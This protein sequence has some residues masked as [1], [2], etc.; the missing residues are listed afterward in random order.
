MLR[1]SLRLTNLQNYHL[2]NEFLQVEAIHIPVRIK[3]LEQP[4]MWLLEKALD[5]TSATRFLGFSSFTNGEE[6]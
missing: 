1:A 6:T 4:G 5:L 2:Y 3:D